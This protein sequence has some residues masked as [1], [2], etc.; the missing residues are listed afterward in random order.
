V[1]AVIWKESDVRREGLS[2]EAVLEVMKEQGAHGNLVVIDASRRNPYERRFRRF[3]HGLA[4]INAPDKALILT[5]AAP[6]K[7]ADDSKNQ[8]SVLMAELLNN[9][10]VQAAGA[11]TVFNKTSVAISR[12]SDNEQIPSVS[13]SLSTDV[14][15]GSAADR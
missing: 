15:L 9:L 11:E 7:V 5:S 10:N 6:G 4:P 14:Q 12:A 8:Y 13:S 2:I 1:D 3:S